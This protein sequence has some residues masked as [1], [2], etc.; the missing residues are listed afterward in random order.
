MI[1]HATWKRQQTAG[2]VCL[3]QWWIWVGCRLKTSTKLVFWR[4]SFRRITS[5]KTCVVMK[6]GKAGSR[7]NTLSIQKQLNPVIIDATDS[8]LWH[9]LAHVQDHVTPCYPCHYCTFYTPRNPLRPPKNNNS[10]NINVTNKSTTVLLWNY[11]PGLVRI[12]CEWRMWDDTPWLIDV[13]KTLSH[14][15]MSTQWA[16][17][18]GLSRWGAS[19]ADRWMW[20]PGAVNQNV[21][22]DFRNGCG[23]V[24]RNSHLW[25]FGCESLRNDREQI[26]VW[27]PPQYCTIFISSRLLC[28][29]LLGGVLWRENGT[30]F[31]VH[32]LQFVL[33]LPQTSWL[34]EMRPQ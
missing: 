15:P 11:C 13:L 23:C 33:V 20:K 21:C 6:H 34:N 24:I 14:P 16:T 19:T 22:V 18:G 3:L 27:P 30:G 1:S 4:Y 12:R 5:L 25:L 8:L 28:V 2:A 7:C 9:F 10:T 31:F 32:W 26:C 17:R 29:I